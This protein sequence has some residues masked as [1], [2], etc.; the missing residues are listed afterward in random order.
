MLMIFSL[1]GF[2]GGPD[3]PLSVFLVKDM[4]LVKLFCTSYMSTPIIHHVSLVIGTK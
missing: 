3:L 4:K 2:A 1:E